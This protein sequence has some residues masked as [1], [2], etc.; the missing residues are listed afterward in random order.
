MKHDLTI[1]IPNRLVRSRIRGVLTPAAG[2]AVYRECVTHPDW[3]PHFDHLLVYEKIDL[4]ELSTEAVQDMVQRFKALDDQY[5]QGITSKAATVMDSQLQAGILSF[6]EH[7]SAPELVTEEAIFE[8][9]DEAL[10]WLG[11]VE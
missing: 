7:I 9:M 1:D 8:T 10:V 5:R 11:R 4:S 6:H 3:S 2:E